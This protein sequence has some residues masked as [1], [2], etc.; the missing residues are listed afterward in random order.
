MIEVNPVC[1]CLKILEAV[2]HLQHV[3]LLLWIWLNHHLSCLLPCF[4]LLCLLNL[5]LFISVLVRNILVFPPFLL[6]GF[7][8]ELILAMLFFRFISPFLSMSFCRKIDKECSFSAFHLDNKLLFVSCFYPTSIVRE[9]VCVSAASPRAVLHSFV[10]AF[11]QRN[12]RK[13]KRI[14]EWHKGFE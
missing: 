4:Q 3:T 6:F 8:R 14:I 12:Q 7:G 13:S 2:A 11:A 1:C 5:D 10:G 9:S